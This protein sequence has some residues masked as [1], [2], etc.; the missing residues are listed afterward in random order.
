MSKKRSLQNKFSRRDF[1]KLAGVGAAGVAVTGCKTEAA[2]PEPGQTTEPQKS[3][4]FPYTVA[5]TQAESYDP[6]IL[7]TKV[8]ELLDYIGAKYEQKDDGM[9]IEGTTEDF[10]KKSFKYNTDEDHRLAFAAEV[11]NKAGY[12]IKIKGTEVVN[13]SFPEFWD[14]MQGKK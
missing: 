10:R 1:L 7:H 12:N 13:K 6:A 5:I 11:L 2:A 4:N 9:I 8:G 14:I 3:T